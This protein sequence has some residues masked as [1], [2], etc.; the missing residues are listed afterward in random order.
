MTGRIVIGPQPGLAGRL[1]EALFPCWVRLRPRSSGSTRRRCK[2]GPEH[3][4]GGPPGGA[5]RAPAQ[6]STVEGAIR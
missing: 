6:A 1:A 3:D 5:V 4:D 2:Q